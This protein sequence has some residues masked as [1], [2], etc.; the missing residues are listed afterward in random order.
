MRTPTVRRRTLVLGIVACVTVLACVVVLAVPY[1]RGGVQ[2]AWCDLTGQ[3]CAEAPGWPQ[4]RPGATGRYV[5]L[6]PSEAATW[7][8]YF[9]LGDSYS[10]GDGAGEYLEGTT[11]KDGCWR[12]ANAYPEAV[13]DSYDFAGELSFLACSGQRG[14]RMIES[15]ESGDSQLSQVTPHTSLVTLGIGGND[16][17]FA[18]VFKTCLMRVPLL[19]SRACV[20]QEK[21]IDKRMRHFEST[22]E[23]VITEVRDRAPDSRVLVLG[24]PRLFPAQ[25]DGM[26]Y[27]LTTADQEWINTTT[28]RFNK[29]IADA[30]QTVDADIRE[31]REAGSVEFVSVY[32][33][34]KGH[35]VGTEEPWIR[36]VEL[37]DITTD[38]TIDRSSFHPT[39]SG[40]QA[41]GARV[42]SR[43]D[44]GP[45]RALYATRATY[46]N[47][48]PETLAAELD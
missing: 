7:G 45:G 12:S 32:S 2:Q 6:S 24:Y 25:P 28:K 23:D 15:L 19:D 26:Y 3:G 41:V 17:G 8:N 30:V 37:R 13:A 16:L 10:S 46:E 47:A 43:I 21:D 14:N 40:Q 1:T 20:G 33:T 44:E 48:D 4:E 31:D 22:F 35:E 18:S 11:G 29:Q 42:R 34:T 39:A 5:K 27:T 38:A 9:A 36:G